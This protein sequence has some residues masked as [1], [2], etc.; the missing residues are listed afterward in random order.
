[1]KITK[2]Q[3]K[4]II[5]EEKQKLMT[6]M[7]DLGQPDVSELL[8]N[9]LDAMQKSKIE[10]Y[11]W[12]QMLDAMRSMGAEKALDVFEAALDE[13]ENNEDPDQVNPNDPEGWESHDLDVDAMR[14]Y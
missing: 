12:E 9:L 8:M 13:Y 7:L 11:Y 2:R 1:M 5:R 14:R 6:E 4:Q 3:L 10:P